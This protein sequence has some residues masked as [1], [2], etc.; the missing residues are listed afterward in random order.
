MKKPN[1]IEIRFPGRKGTF[2]SA[3]RKYF[4]RLE[5]KVLKVNFAKSRERKIF[6]YKVIGSRFVAANSWGNWKKK[7]YWS[8]NL[9]LIVP[10]EDL[11]K[12]L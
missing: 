3:K 11:N 6:E 1:N 8:L 7:P 4:S 2:S 9:E 5:N 10:E 12:V